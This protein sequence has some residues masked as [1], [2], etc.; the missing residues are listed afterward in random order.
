MGMGSCMLL[1]TTS[2]AVAHLATVAP[3]RKSAEYF[4]QSLFLHRSLTNG[5]EW[6]PRKLHVRKCKALLCTKQYNCRIRS[7]QNQ[8]GTARKIGSR[9][10]SLGLWLWSMSVPILVD[11]INVKQFS[12]VI[13]RIFQFNV[14]ISRSWRSTGGRPTTTIVTIVDFDKTILTVGWCEMSAAGDVC[15]EQT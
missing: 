9:L 1:A 4:H 7:N 2:S 14:I 11:K 8:A 15:S 13:R 10:G 3:T 6:W 12:Q 5:D